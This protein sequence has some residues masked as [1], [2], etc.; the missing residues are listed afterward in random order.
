MDAISI[1]ARE[2]ASGLKE[3]NS[4]VNHMDQATQ[5]NAAMVEEMNAA[6]FGLAQESEKLAQLL[7]NFRTSGSS[8]ERNRQAA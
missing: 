6:S 1:A 4:A 3:I 5:Q 8:A 2:Q 7:S